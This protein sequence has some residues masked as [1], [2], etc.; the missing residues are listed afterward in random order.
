MKAKQM[1]AQFDAQNTERKPAIRRHSAQRRMFA[2]I[3]AAAVLLVGGAVTVGAA[4][5]WNYATVFSKYFSDQSG[6]HV[7]Y[8]FTGMGLDIGEVIEGDRFTMT[9]QSVVA[10]TNAVYV[11]YDIALSDEIN[12]MLAPYEEV[13]VNGFLFGSVFS[14]NDDGTLEYYGHSGRSLLGYRTEDNSWRC[15]TIEQMDDS[16]NLQDKK[17]MLGLNSDIGAVEFA[18]FEP[19]ADEGRGSPWT[20][21]SGPKTTLIYDLADITVQQG[22]SVPYGSTLPNDVNENIFDTMT[23]TPFMVR[24]ESKG[25]VGRG[26]SA[27]SWGS[28]PEASEAYQPVV[29]TA[30]YADRTEVLKVTVG[31]DET[32]CTHTTGEFSISHTMFFNAPLDLNGLLAIRVNDIEIPVQ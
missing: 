2:G 8:D 26:E 10:D 28:M 16:V 29:Y 24:F 5:D 9:I 30:V 23:V 12:E 11:V 18:Y 14:E 13:Y 25:T 4:N 31:G 19:D 21:L 3:A 7:N 20:R 17:L 6:E 15:M 27:P 32:E 22:L 1:Q